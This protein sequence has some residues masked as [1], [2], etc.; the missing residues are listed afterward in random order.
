MPGKIKPSLLLLVIATLTAGFTS[1][2]YEADYDALSAFPA[3]DR[4][5][6]I[7]EIELIPIVRKVSKRQARE[8]QTP[9]A[10]SAKQQTVIQKGVVGYP[11]QQK[12]IRRSG[13]FEQL[14]PL[15]TGFK[16]TSSPEI[17]AQD[18]EQIGS[19]FTGSGIALGDVD[20]DGLS[21]VFVASRSNGGRLFKNLGGFNFKDVT[22]SVGLDVGPIWGTSPTMMDVNDDGLL[23]IYLC[24]YNSP[25]RLF[26]NRGGR[27][28][29]QSERYGLDFSGASTQAAF[30]DYD[31]DGD[32]DLYLVTNRLIP[33]NP[34]RKLRLE[35]S[36]GETPQIP[37]EFREQIRMLQLPD[38]SYRVIE[39]GQFDYLFRNEGY[40]F[41]DVTDE[42]GI[43][44]HPFRGMAAV[45]WDFNNDQWPDIYVANDHHDPDQL[46]RNNGADAEGRVT[47][48]EVGADVLQH[49]PFLSKGIDFGDLNNDGLED[50]VGTGV[51]G[52]GHVEKLM[53]TGNLYGNQ[54]DAWFLHHG[55]PPQ[56][57]AN[58][59]LLNTGT[60]HLI[61]VAQL[62]DTADTDWTWSVRVADLDHDGLQDLV[63]STGRVRDF[64]NNDLHREMEEQQE[65]A[66]QSKFD[67]WLDKPMVR[68]ADRVFRNLG[69][70]T[71][72]DN[73]SDW[74]IDEPFVSQSLATA[75]LDN[76]G[77]LDLVCSGF[78][79][80]VRI[81]RNELKTQNSIRLKL[82]G[83]QTNSHGVGVRI[84][85]QVE[86]DGPEQIRFLNPARGFMTCNEPIV[87]FG[88]GEATRVHRIQ[89]DWPLGI[90]QKMFELKSNYLYRIEEPAAIQRVSRR[91]QPNRNRNRKLFSIDRSTF[92]LARP[93][94]LDFDDFL[95]QP[96]L[97]FQLSEMG[98]TISWADIDNDGD[99]D[100]FRCG[101][102]FDV[103]A[104]YLNNG[105]SGFVK[106]PQTCFTQDRR[107]EDLG[108]VF[109]DADGDQDL[110]LYVVSGGVESD[111][112]DAAMQ[113]RL[114]LNDGRGTFEKSKGLLPDL[115]LSGSS[116]AAGDYDRDGRVDLFIGGRVCPGRYPENPGSILL[117]NTGTGFEDAT[118]NSAPELSQS[119]MVLSSIWLDLD[120]DDWLDLVFATE[121]GPVRVFRNEEGKL[122][123]QSVAAGTAGR[124]G[125]FHSLC[126]GDVDNDGDTDLIV[127]NLGLNTQ[128]QASTA[129]PLYIY[130]GRFGAA[131]SSRILEAV[132]EQGVIYPRRGLERL[133]EF[134]PQLAKQFSTVSEFA[135]TPLDQVFPQEE[136]QRA[137]RLEA[138]FL[139]SGILLNQSDSN[140]IRFEFRPLPRLAQTS[141]IYG[142]QL[143]DFNADGH[144]DLLALQNNSA[145]FSET[146]PFDNGIGLLLLGKGDATFEPVSAT[147]SG[148]ELTANGTALTTIDLN[149]DGRVDFVAAT[150]NDGIQLLENRSSYETAAIDLRKLGENRDYL[151]TKV[152]LQLTDG[153]QQLHQITSNS[154][155]LAQSPPIVHVG[156]SVVQGVNIRWPDGTTREYDLNTGSAQ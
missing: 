138:N 63:Y 39:S 69:D 114:Y 21:D 18:A 8:E 64:L 47:F 135:R 7:K 33:E 61:D 123:E 127:G 24:C 150:K 151:G 95:D 30:A 133:Q 116:V 137:T 117:R 66:D 40:R 121:W 27:F 37:K 38:R 75:D 119:G 132:S 4:K 13:K 102:A 90:S 130:H 10:A 139:E 89:I 147:E 46:F 105:P 124:T 148:L 152:F 86:E 115:T 74:G 80:E 31:G 51:S 50:L 92:D 32:L 144:L 52:S 9:A 3:N 96:L 54:G 41:V 146:V 77:D 16:V 99:Y 2:R 14:N 45:W 79:E 76:D 111:A 62:A 22:A 129:D 81:Y 70:L 25:N 153:S 58:V 49:V 107:S 44:R 100:L 120:N 12:T 28:R 88:V 68:T 48:T 141:P 84:K 91:A 36:A 20:G 118:E 104:I 82:V 35:R 113:D 145:V 67:F 128:Y 6:S 53:S 72:A 97:P 143:V 1:C 98:P 103:S 156:K 112:G 34:P 136:L 26:I 59:L 131:E 29:E 65:E 60:N 19:P 149:D 55:L 71:F 93:A 140:G 108:A 23:D 11:Y 106:S 94:E 101:P 17:N 15:S 154:G 125:L 43:D 42:S 78:G 57:L 56:Q 87:H 110:D 5:L 126:P 122:V 142:T 85:L 109:F 134:F 83:T 155:Y 73:S